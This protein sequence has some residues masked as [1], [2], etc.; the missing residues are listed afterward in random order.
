MMDEV[1]SISCDVS[2]QQLSNCDSFPSNELCNPVVFCT[3]GEE[4]ERWLK[5]YEWD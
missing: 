4:R 2:N 1:N 5:L 3:I